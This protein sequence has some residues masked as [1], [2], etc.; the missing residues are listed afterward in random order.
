MKKILIISSVIAAVGIYACS[1][2][3]TTGGSGVTPTATPEAGTNSDIKISLNNG[4]ENTYKNN[5]VLFAYTKKDGLVFNVRVEDPNNSS[6][7]LWS[8]AISIPNSPSSSLIGTHTVTKDISADVKHVIG[9]YKV[10][11]GKTEYD[12][13]RCGTPEGTITINEQVKLSNPTPGYFKGYVSGTFSFTVCNSDGKSAT[14]K[15]SFQK[16]STTMNGEF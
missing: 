6:S 15:G 5:G 11:P 14:V 13:H 10:D 4:P 7:N 12:T 8:I 1:N 3:S 2:N 16:L 9:Y